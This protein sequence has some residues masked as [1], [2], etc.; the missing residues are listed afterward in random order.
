MGKIKLNRNKQLHIKSGDTVKVVLLRDHA[1]HFLV[2]DIRYMLHSNYEEDSLLE[3]YFAGQNEFGKLNLYLMKS[4]MSP[5]LNGVL[6][7][8]KLYRDENK[9]ISPIKAAG[10][11]YRDIECG[12]LV[13]SLY[14]LGLITLDKEL[15]K[16]LGLIEREKNIK[17]LQRK[18]K[19]AEERVYSLQNELY[20]LRGY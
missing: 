5:S 19:R 10:V 9:R 2:N 8:I 7:L 3:L 16:S 18:L 6:S 20:A 14:L 1:I 13:C 15:K 17:N 11:V 12:E 4:V